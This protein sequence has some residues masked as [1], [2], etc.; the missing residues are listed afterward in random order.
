M[1]FL[2]FLKTYEYWKSECTYMYLNVCKE[3]VGKSYMRI[4]TTYMYMVSGSLMSYSPIWAIFER[5]RIWHEGT[6][7]VRFYP[8]K[9]IIWNLKVFYSG[10]R[11]GYQSI[12]TV[13]YKNVWT[14]SHIKFGWNWSSRFWDI[15]LHLKMRQSYKA[16]L[17]DLGCEILGHTC[18]LLPG[19]RVLN[20]SFI[21]QFSAL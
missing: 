20:Y 6:T 7:C 15:G 16:L 17:N 21:S 4:G 1:V 5:K 9:I 8:N 14:T 12:F 10:S 11:H 2:S 19:S 18:I 3:Q 13:Y